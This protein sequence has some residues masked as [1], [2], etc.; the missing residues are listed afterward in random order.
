MGYLVQFWLNYL[1]NTLAT[2]LIDRLE[3]CW[4]EWEQ[5]ILLLSF[6]LHPEY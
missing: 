5:P 2:K 4:N 1:D 6:L 3:K